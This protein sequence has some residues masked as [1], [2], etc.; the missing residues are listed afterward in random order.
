M[1]LIKIYINNFGKFK[2]FELDLKDNINIIYGDNEAG[3]STLMAFILMVF[4]GSKSRKQNPLD[5]PR[6]KYRPWAGGPM[7]GY[8]IFEDSGVEYRLE[9]IFE[10]TNQKD[11]VSLINNISG[12]KIEIE[13]PA[14]PGK[15]FFNMSQESFEKSLF[16]DSEDLAFSDSSGE[17][18]EKLINLSTTSDEDI[19]YEKTL[20]IIEKKYYEFKSKSGKKGILVD[21]E[22]RI[23]DEKKALQ[24]AKLLE[25]EKMESEKRL[26]R[27]EREIE[28]ESLKE[29]IDKNQDL[30]LKAKDS[31]LR[32]DERKSLE[33]EISQ[34]EDGRNQIF[35]RLDS[36]KFS[37]YDKLDKSH[38]LKEEKTLLFQESLELAHA[39]EDLQSKNEEPKFQLYKSILMLL[40]LGLLALGIFLYYKKINQ[41]LAYAAIALG[42]CFVLIKFTYLDS[43]LKKS[44]EEWKSR[45]EFLEEKERKLS[46]ELEGLDQVLEEK[47]NEIDDLSL[48]IKEDEIRLELLEKD[49]SFKK[50]RFDSLSKAPMIQVFDPSIIKTEEIKLKDLMD[51]Y[52]KELDQ[53]LSSYN[54]LLDYDQEDRLL[55]LSKSYESLK[56]ASREKFKNIRYQ[57]EVK[58]KIR[59]LEEDLAK[60]R[61]EYKS[62]E[63]SLELLDKAYFKMSKDFGPILNKKS[64]EIFSK[65]TKAKY[66]KLL[67]GSEMDINYEESSHGQIKNWQYL[68]SGARDQAYISL[69][70]GL[71]KML[72]PDKRAFLLLDDI[73]VKFD[74]NR[75]KDGLNLLN[76]LV[77]DFEQIILFT[78][79]KRIYDMADDGVNK[80][81]L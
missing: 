43:R 4:Y 51:K 72:F 53:Y 61:Q 60:K 67:I 66:D 35:A 18:K 78:C 24:E 71:A 2:D 36:L 48:K 50:E 45:L 77:S 68:S 25:L 52:Q 22:E 81:V 17:L 15:Y 31:N 3:K 37:Y 73:F 20:E 39:K 57:D 29:K 79:H 1:K 63:L 76:N 26:E 7:K 14:E 74:E 49:F 9:R 42:F 8:I 34:Y 21:L 69:K 27:L 55:A 33:K 19:S 54:N 40:A 44:L 16:I 59:I 64:Q 65:F 41:S 62:L 58:E 56:A 13:N 28:L 32:N 11:Q 46:T 5:N 38:K 30:L 80:Q 10:E 6:L 75:A 12:Q 47:K 23:Y 70:I